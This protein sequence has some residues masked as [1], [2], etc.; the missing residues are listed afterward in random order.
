MRLPSGGPCSP[1]IICWVGR[2][3]FIGPAPAVI[4]RHRDRRRE[5]PFLTGGAD[6]G[7]GGRAD[8]L[9]QRRVA[10]RAKADVL[11]EQRRADDVAVAMHRI[12]APQDRDA[13]ATLR[14]VR[15][16]RPEPVGEFQPLRG[17]GVV[18]TA[19]PGVAAVQYGADVI[20]PHFLRRDVGDVGLEDL[21]DLFLQRHALQQ[22]GDAGLVGGDRA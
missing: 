13:D 21:A 17:R 7:S 10:H 1:R 22:V 6:L 9:D 19:R 4:L 8:P 20:P 16:R 2:I 11:G 3:A 5:R 15:R 18:V 14:R 12:G